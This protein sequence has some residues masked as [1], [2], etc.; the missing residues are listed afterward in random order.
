VKNPARHL[1]ATCAL[2]LS[3]TTICAGASEVPSIAA[4]DAEAHLL[5]HTAPAYPPLAKS[6]RIEGT[7]K[8][9]LA[10]SSTGAVTDATAISGHPML[11]A[12]AVEAAKQWKYQPFLVHNRPTKVTA[13]VEIP[14]S[15]DIAKPRYQSE[16]E[17]RDAYFKQLY[18]CTGL[19]RDQRYGKAESEC[20]QAVALAES[21]A[22]TRQLERY[23]AYRQLGH[24][25]QAQGRYSGALDAYSWE[26]S[27]A[28]KSLTNRYTELA[29]AYLDVAHADVGL[30]DADAATAHYEKA[31]TTLT[32]GKAHVA[33][34][35]ELSE[36]SAVEQQALRDYAALLRGMGNSAKASA[37]DKKADAIVART[38][39]KTE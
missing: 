2:V 8:L 20:L 39:H 19:V 13:V 33:S 10:I 22:A 4:K 12:S 38:D 30:A 6:A 25:L 7:V 34:A 21:L 11:I 35:S 9:K 29:N 24:V 15:L 28:R 17:A 16:Q 31:I 37:M 14:F 3:F 23:E 18:T 32:L 36:L 26:L 1:P 5:T 27:I